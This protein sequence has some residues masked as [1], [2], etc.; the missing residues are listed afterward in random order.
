[1]FIALIYL[2][3]GQS[4]VRTMILRMTVLIPRGS[5]NLQNIIIP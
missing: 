4:K 1:M 5:Y 2:I 3:F